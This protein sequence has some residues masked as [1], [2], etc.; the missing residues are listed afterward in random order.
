MQLTR[1]ELEDIWEN[2]PYGYFAKMLKERKGTKKYRVTTE[3][4]KTSVIVIGTDEQEVWAKD[5]TAAQGLVH[6]QAVL[7]LRNKHGLAVWDSSVVF[8]TKAISI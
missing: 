5:A 8:S 7:R 2:R 1:Q 4:R 6:Q 3:V